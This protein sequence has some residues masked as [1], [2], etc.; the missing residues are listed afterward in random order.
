[1]GVEI[2]IELRNGSGDLRPNLHRD[3]R[4]DRAGCIHD[5]A[6]LSPLHLRGEMRE[7]LAAVEESRPNQHGERTDAGRYS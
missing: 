2:G 7:A 3:D 1:V 5:V 4:I 6:D